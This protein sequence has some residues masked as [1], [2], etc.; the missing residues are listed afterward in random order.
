MGLLSFIF[1]TTVSNSTTKYQHDNRNTSSNYNVCEDCNYEDEH[2]ECCDEY[3]CT[4]SYND[5]EHD[6]YSYNDDDDC[7]CSCEDCE[8]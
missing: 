4:D 8:Y 7:E 3:D 2:Y 5:Y 6:D 1:G